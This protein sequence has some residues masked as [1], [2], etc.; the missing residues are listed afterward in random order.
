MKKILIVEDEPMI[1]Q[2]L[3]LTVKEAGYSVVGPCD[4]AERALELYQSEK[5]SLALLDINIHGSKDGIE[6]AELISGQ[7]PFIFITSYYDE[8]TLKRVEKVNAQAYILKPF[9]DEEVLMN[10][11]LAFAKQQTQPANP[12]QVNLLIRSGANSVAICPSDVVYARGEDNYTRV[13]LRNK[14]QHVISQTLK[15]FQ[16]KLDDQFCRVHKSYVINSA[17]IEGISSRKVLVQGN[18]IPLGR[19]YKAAFM[20][21]LNLS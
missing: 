2:D 12:N 6:L 17:L 4:R 3:M 13:V 21:S 1:A 11:R 10:I 16:E 20:D 9:R 15:A 8:A 14:E 19:S 5:P 18:E 7:I